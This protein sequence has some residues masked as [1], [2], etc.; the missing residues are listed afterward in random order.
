MHL[1]G[2]EAGMPENG[3]VWIGASGLKPAP[4]LASFDLEA[5]VP[6]ETHSVPLPHSR[7][8]RPS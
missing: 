3:S 7:H 6:G 8:A 5:Q 1:P 4:G 2:R